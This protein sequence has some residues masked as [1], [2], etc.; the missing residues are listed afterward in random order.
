MLFSLL[1]AI[2]SFAIGMTAKT[3]KSIKD[4]IS[5]RNSAYVIL[6][7]YSKSHFYRFSSFKIMFSQQ[8]VVPNY[9]QIFNL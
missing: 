2:L 3:N 5:I 6:K 4:M 8:N 1:L 9:L 7:F